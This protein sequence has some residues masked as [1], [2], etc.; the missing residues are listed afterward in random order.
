LMNTKMMARIFSVMGKNGCQLPVPS[1]QL[2]PL[3]SG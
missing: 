1:C 2:R 3:S